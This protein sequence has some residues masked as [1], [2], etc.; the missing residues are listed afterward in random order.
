MAD[1][2]RD[3]VVRITLEQI[4]ATLKA[5]DISP[6]ISAQNAVNQAVQDAAVKQAGTQKDTQSAWDKSLAKLEEQSKAYSIASKEAE[7]LEA[8]AKKAAQAEAKAVKEAAKEKAEALELRK[9]EREWVKEIS[10]ANKKAFADY[11]EQLKKKAEA[12]QKASE[13]AKAAAEKQISSQLRVLEA[14]KQVGTGT[15]QLARGFA[16]LSTSTDENFQK[17]LQTIAKFQ[18]GFDIIAGGVDVIKGMVEGT[19]ALKS[20]YGVA[21]VAAGLQA[22]AQTAVTAT[23]ATATAAVTALKVALGPI[24][25]IVTGIGV[26]TASLAAAWKLSAASANENEQAIRKLTDTQEK[27]LK[28]SQLQL[29][30]AKDLRD[31]DKQTADIK[32][33]QLAG[34]EK[35][36]AL[37][38]RIGK[39][40]ISFDSDTG[41]ITTLA[42]RQAEAE[43]IAAS[44]KSAPSQSSRTEG[45]QQEQLALNIL[46]QRVDI[47]Q[48]DIQFQQQI[49]DIKEQT[50]ESAAQQL[51]RERQLVA[52][53]K[54]GIDA[55]KE[56]LALEENKLKSI[57]AQIG[58]LS[59]E[60]QIELKMLADKVKAGEELTRVQLQRAQQLGGDLTRQ[61]VQDQQAKAGRPI[62]GEIGEAFGVNITA[63]TAQA[64]AALTRALQETQAAQERARAAEDK[65]LEATDSF[66]QAAAVMDKFAEIADELGKRLKKIE[67]DIEVNQVNNE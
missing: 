15:F 25:L 51:E 59:K 67:S 26:A 64:G 2:I 9:R 7:A 16:F 24:G 27:A 32:L 61:F 11:Q 17:M 20:A 38:S 13:T 21:T 41:R 4:Q 1:I 39:G 55:A 8:A 23:A 6:F 65:L 52:E 5:P 53:S 30:L 62:A 22:A 18:G 31:I 35:L 3:V 42:E 57:E 58:A 54:K 12:E 37:K 43:R 48:Q 10:D 60:E 66:N 36:I 44:R 29:D 63:G 46:R 56:K 19:M 47:S 50:K 49:K 33:A 28:L 45:L 34:E 40:N 14:T